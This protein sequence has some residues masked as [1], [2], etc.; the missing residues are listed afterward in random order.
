MGMRV[1]S[2]AF[3]KESTGASFLLSRID[4]QSSFKKTDFDFVIGS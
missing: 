3:L 1:F 4:S 2:H